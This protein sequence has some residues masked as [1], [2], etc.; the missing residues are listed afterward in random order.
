M[1]FLPIFTIHRC[2]DRDWAEF[3]RPAN[4]PSRFMV[5]DQEALAEIEAGTAWAIYDFARLE[6]EVQ[7]KKLRRNP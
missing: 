7:I 1:F 2:L 3:R 4:S 5:S 6:F